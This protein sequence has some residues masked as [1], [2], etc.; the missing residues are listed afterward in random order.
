MPRAP[1]AAAGPPAQCL[2]CLSDVSLTPERVIYESLCVLPLLAP[3]AR[4][5]FFFGNTPKNAP[6]CPRFVRTIRLGTSD[7]ASRSHLMR[8]GVDL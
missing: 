6:F 7:Y 3:A 8:H 4:F 1:R 2:S 5:F